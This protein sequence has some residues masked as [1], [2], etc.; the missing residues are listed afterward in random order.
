[1]IINGMNDVTAHGL[2]S[3]ERPVKLKARTRI[4]SK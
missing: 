2:L 1:V 3:S 4:T